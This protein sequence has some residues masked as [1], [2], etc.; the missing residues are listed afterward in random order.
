[1]E[2]TI[3]KSGVREA[4]G[5]IFCGPPGKFSVWEVTP[6]GNLMDRATVE[7]LGQM[8][9]HAGAVDYRPFPLEDVDVTTFSRSSGRFLSTEDAVRYADIFRRYA[10]LPAVNER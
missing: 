10:G 2:V 1:M 3:T 6:D 9:V 7:A 4:Y 8:A 5:V